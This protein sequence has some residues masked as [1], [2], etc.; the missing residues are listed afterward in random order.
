[1]TKVELISSY[2]FYLTIEKLKSY[3]LCKF[4]NNFRRIRKLIRSLV[5]CSEC[6]IY[7]IL[8]LV[9]LLANGT[10]INANKNIKNIKSIIH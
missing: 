8:I 10:H 5:N 6:N 7:L 2:L 4:M 1:M 3:A 9:G